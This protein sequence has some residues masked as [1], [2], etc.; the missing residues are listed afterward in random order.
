MRGKITAVNN[1]KKIFLTTISIWIAA[2]L[3]MDVVA[4]FLNNL[5]DTVH[6]RAIRVSAG[7]LVSHGTIVTPPVLF[8]LGVVV[9]SGLVSLKNKWATRGGTIVLILWMLLIG[10][11]V[12]LQGAVGSRA[13]QYTPEHWHTVVALGWVVVI[14]S[15]P[16]VV[17][18]VVYLVRTRNM[19]PSP[20]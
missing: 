7:S 13:S 8:L 11:G 2:I 16:V 15:V 14:F 20:P 5:G 6:H 1:S 10:I 3:V 18:G 12:G 4:L 19:K 17:T 9:L